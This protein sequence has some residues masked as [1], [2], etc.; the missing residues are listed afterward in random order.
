VGLPPQA[1][2]SGRT[3]AWLHGLDLPPCD[4]VEVT[5]PRLATTSRRTGLSVKRS[6]LIADDIAEVHDLRATSRVRTVA[7]LARRLPLVDAVAVLDMA[8]H[9]RLVLMQE[10]T[11]W[12][13]CHRGYHGLRRLRAAADLAD[14]A[15]ESPMETRL[16]ILLIS[17]GLPKPSLQVSLY[18]ETGAFIARPDLYYSGVR[19]AI[20]YDGATHRVRLAADDRRQNRLL[21]AG[22]RLLRF[23]AGDIIRTPASVVGQV[24]RALSALVPTG[25]GTQG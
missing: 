18:D 15:A 8:L 25:A 6:N 1:V 24:E 20:E 17:N 13:G 7:D 12:I 23:T 11:E 21:E 9:R 19:L 3:A 14:A 22:Y 16:R 5:L 2:F 10:L 4:P